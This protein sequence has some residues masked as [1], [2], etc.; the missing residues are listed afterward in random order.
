MKLKIH[1]LFGHVFLCPCYLM[2]TFYYLSYPFFLFVPSSTQNPQFLP[3]VSLKRPLNW[4]KIRNGRL[5][6]N[7]HIVKRG[8]FVTACNYSTKYITYYNMIYIIRSHY[9]SMVTGIKIFTRI[10]W[11]K[12][13]YCV[14]YGTDATYLTPQ[15]KFLEDL[16]Y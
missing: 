16:R 10:N 2:I 7:D 12:F 14:L 9:S 1:S 11:F 4:P 3:L 5:L 15:S 6:Q 13:C 8:N